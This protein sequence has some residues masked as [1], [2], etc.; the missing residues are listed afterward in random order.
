MIRM[1][2]CVP[3]PRTATHYHRMGL[4]SKP[5]MTICISRNRVNQTH[6]AD[7]ST[8][9]SINHEVKYV[10]PPLKPDLFLH[11]LIS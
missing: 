5:R 10:G 7:K 1:N 11:E 4:V 6:M 3:G 9:Q 2:E 8:N